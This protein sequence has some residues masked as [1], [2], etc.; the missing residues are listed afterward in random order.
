MVEASAGTATPFVSTA[1]FRVKGLLGQGA[2]GVVYRV[3][4]AELGFD[5]AL[6]TLP[7]LD[8]G[9][10]YDLKQEFR[11]RA[12]LEHPNLVTLHELFLE[13]ERCFFTM[14]L[15][16]GRDFTEFFGRGA[17]P[18]DEAWQ[19][20]LRAAL[21]QLVAAVAALH[22]GGLM[23]CDIK[24]G[25]V[26]MAREGRAV[27]LDFGLA[28]ALAPD[29]SAA[30]SGA[31]LA[32]TYEYL[33]PDELLGRPRSAA[34]DWYSLGVML[35][36]LVA[37]EVPFARE[38]GG[39]MLARRGRQAPPRLRAL[40]PEAPSWLDELTAALLEPIP[41]RRPDATAIAD[42][43]GRAGETG[44]P[45]ARG[46]V[47]VPF[48]GRRAELDGLRAALSA[49][50]PGEPAAVHLSGPSG[51]GKSELVRAF[52]REAS[53]EARLMLLRS[54]CHPQESVPF[55]ALD[56][57]IDDL[58][59]HLIE[60]SPAGGCAL[61]DAGPLLRL[62][63]VLR[64]VPG[65]DA[66][67]AE[68]DVDAR[69][70]RQR[71]ARALREI[72]SRIGAEQPVVLW[73]DDLQWG[74]LDSLALLRAILQ[75]P[76]APA[77]L[78]VTSSR[79][80]D[81][82]SN[83][84]LGALAHDPWPLDAARSFQ[85]EL[86]PLP[87]A[88]SL[89]LARRWLPG[90]DA[91]RLDMVVRDS[92][93]SPFFV[94]ELA[95]AGA[96]DGPGSALDALVAQRL[97]ALPELERRVLEV[98]S[99]AG[100]PLPEHLVLR[101]AALE[102]GARPLLSSLERA[103]LLRSAPRGSGPVFDTYH[104]RIREAVVSHLAPESL[105]GCHRVLADALSREPDPDPE[106]LFTHT[107]GAGDRA[108]A[109]I[110][111][112]RAA[113]R[114]AEA[115]AFER[116]SQLYRQALD[117]GPAVEQRAR[118]LERLGE[119]LV[120]AGRGATS[121]PVFLEA[122][123]LREGDADAAR[124]LRRLAAEQLVRNGQVDEGTD[125]FRRILGEVSISLPQSSV[126]A[127]RRSALGLARFVVRGARFLERREEELAPRIA[128]RLDAMWGACGGLGMM[129]P[130]LGSAVAIQFLLEA[131]EAG[132]PRRIANGL[133]YEAVLESAIGG[134]FFHRRV[135]RHLEAAERLAAAHDDPTTRG[136]V[137]FSRGAAAWHAGRFDEALRACD[138]AIA[139]YDGCRG[140]AWHRVAAE[141]YALSSLA[142]L[143]ELR[144]LPA[145]RRQ[146]LESARERGD[147]FG[148]AVFQIGQLN[149][150]RLAED[151]PAHAIAEADAVKAS[152][153]LRHYHHTIITVQA[154]LYRGALEA[155]RARL[156]AAW[157]EL[158][159][160]RLLALEFPRIELLHLRAQVALAAPASGRPSA[161][162]GRADAARV[163]AWAWRIAQS[164]L[165]PAAPFAASIRAGAAFLE[166]ERARAA[167]L[168]A[169]AA[170]GYEAAGMA[171]HAAA[172]RLARAALDERSSD[173]ARSARQ[174]LAVLG[175]RR[176]GRIAR[177]VV[178]WL[179]EDRLER[180]AEER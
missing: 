120:N 135:A 90:A 177:M 151:E 101:A 124:S 17:P 147:D 62:F 152:W 37:G 35:Y 107:L 85:I 171:V 54:R 160:E 175:A 83:P 141:N 45:A 149:L 23:H 39:M 71:G 127:S 22:A 163:R 44:R 52:V 136:F 65:L 145:R 165:P 156:E 109:G 15:I 115:L 25:N 168:L 155:A 112:A 82:G 92:R 94:G 106:A 16:E 174:R 27:L 72:L 117:L 41:E 80:E 159:R 179:P 53:A 48:V 31:L 86:G 70:V 29:V 97:S 14:E 69:I 167:A 161:L 61:P 7:S 19:S 98:T 79:V 9:D 76:E 111:A 103:C 57:A 91:I 8:P 4:D 164:Q 63:P 157:A 77:V 108:G 74:D 46:R 87:P 104:D 178:P 40:R 143:G 73:I 180:A 32:G 95:R 24:P 20:G 122:A 13:G 12:R 162:R 113:E 128:Q 30:G 142:F 173:D 36:E 38:A 146:A 84:I 68:P 133:A 51:I 60:G 102:R 28:R 166:G 75:G 129:N 5:V 64:R 47:D 119:S 131:L 137:F 125:I 58:S 154:E 144:V 93:G 99:V 78:L 153:P 96:H 121:P 130:P 88:D 105:R 176:P 140:I 132:E 26:L 11:Q 3:E 67:T 139:V 118:L 148:A 150:A 172:C 81:A 158:R 89:A 50:A 2:M 134:P 114:A 18:L 170:A 110:H 34:S 42:L 59:E 123:A 100:R 55:K 169:G 6:K 21:R 49:V 116:A 10:G 66:Q 138:A 126:Q 33:P 56:G 1:R 43:L